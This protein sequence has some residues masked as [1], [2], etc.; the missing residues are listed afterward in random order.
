MMRPLACRLPFL[1]SPRNGFLHWCSFPAWFDSMWDTGYMRFCALPLRMT[2]SFI[3][4]TDR[5]GAEDFLGPSPETDLQGASDPMEF[6]RTCASGLDL[7]ISILLW[8]LNRDA[9]LLVGRMMPLKNH[10]LLSL[11]R[12]IALEPRGLTRGSF[13]N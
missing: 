13:R 6:Q 12:G 7:D 2:G 10:L 5:Q 3:N 4:W 11:P 9:Y 8:T 1:F